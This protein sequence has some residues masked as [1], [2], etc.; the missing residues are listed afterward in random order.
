MQLRVGLK[1]QDKLCLLLIYV[2]KYIDS[3]TMKPLESNLNNKLI[4]YDYYLHALKRNT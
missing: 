2:L 4:G 3:A 1:I